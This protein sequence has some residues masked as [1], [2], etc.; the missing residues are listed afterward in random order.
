MNEHNR[1]LK[2]WCP[3]LGSVGKEKKHKNQSTEVG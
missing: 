1:G 2:S 3:F